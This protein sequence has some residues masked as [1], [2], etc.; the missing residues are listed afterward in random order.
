MLIIFYII[1]WRDY[2]WNFIL[3]EDRKEKIV[4]LA[5]SWEGE[6]NEMWNVA[7]SDI[8]VVVNVKCQIA[9]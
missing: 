3:I 6:G 1:F 9:W 2:L 8:S 7:D 4:I 5:I